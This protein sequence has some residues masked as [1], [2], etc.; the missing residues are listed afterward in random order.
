MRA[1][2]LTERTFE[3]A[4][5]MGSTLAIAWGAAKSDPSRVY[6]AIDGD[7]NAQMNEMD[8]VLCSDYPEN[9]YWFILDNGTGESVGTSRSRPLAPWFYDL[10]RVI[11]TRNGA[12]GSFKHPR[13]NA[14][15]LKFASPEAKA[16]AAEIGNL[17][18][19]AHLARRILARRG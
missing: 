13:I 12:P 8:K 18:A 14:S 17:P 9:L 4:G 19:Q 6:V 10:A 2:R 3:N 1:L 16:L 11:P 5:G 7:Q 15:G